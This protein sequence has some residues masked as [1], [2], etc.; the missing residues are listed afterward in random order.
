MATA[1]ERRNPISAEKNSD[2]RVM[3]SQLHSSAHYSKC[4][5]HRSP[6]MAMTDEMQ[7]GRRTVSETIDLNREPTRT[8]RAR[9]AG[10]SNAEGSEVNVGMGERHLSIAVGSAIALLGI[11]RRSI[12]GLVLA[13]IGGGLIYRGVTGHCPAY[14]AMDIETIEDR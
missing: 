4:F 3:A 7:D 1:G 9:E 10:S 5:V 2:F 12:F 13:G 6:L 11:Q 14:D 8:D